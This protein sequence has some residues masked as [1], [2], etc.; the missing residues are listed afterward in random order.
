MDDE[1]G[2]TGEDGKDVAIWTVAKIIPDPTCSDHEPRQPEHDHFVE[3]D[4]TA[5]RTEKYNPRQL[6][7][8]ALSNHQRFTLLAAQNRSSSP[9]TKSFC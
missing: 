4:I 1:T 5:T 9:H 3:F 6:T 2:I 8:R 7:H